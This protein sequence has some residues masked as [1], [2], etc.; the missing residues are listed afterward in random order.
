[1]VV[2]LAN[3]VKQISRK[4]TI[5]VLGYVFLISFSHL[6]SKIQE[7]TEM[8]DLRILH[9]ELR[10]LG[11]EKHVCLKI[12]IKGSRVLCLGVSRKMS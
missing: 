6:C 11:K 9:F 7:K 3:F 1:M 4:P 8:N 5:L 12:K 2:G 10:R